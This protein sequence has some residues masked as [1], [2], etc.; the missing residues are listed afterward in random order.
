MSNLFLPRTI[1]VF[2]F[3]RFNKEMSSNVRRHS[4]IFNFMDNILTHVITAGK[5]RMAQVDKGTFV[6]RDSRSVAEQALQDD[7]DHLREDYAAGKIDSTTFLRNAAKRFLIKSVQKE[8]NTA[9][10]VPLVLP[11]EAAMPEDGD[12]DDPVVEEVNSEQVEPD[13]E[14]DVGAGTVDDDDLQDEGT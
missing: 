2:H 6:N 14:H 7:S 10:R 4:Q 1:H 5:I 13:P 12:E 9:Q 11:E 8:L 3:F